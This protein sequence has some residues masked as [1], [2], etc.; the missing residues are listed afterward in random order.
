MIP[1]PNQILRIPASGLLVK[2]PTL[3]SGNNVGARSWTDGKTERP[4][5]P[6][7]PELCRHPSS[8]EL[9]WYR[10]CELV[11]EEETYAP[12]PEYLEV[13]FAGALRVDDFQKALSDGMANSA[14]IEQYICGRYWWA[15]NDPVR[16]G[17]TLAAS[18][19]DF[20][21]NLLRFCALLGT[22][23]P[24]RRLMNAEAARE[25]KD[26][27]AAKELLHFDFPA[28]YKPFADLL[29]RLTDECNS[30]VYLLA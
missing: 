9:F 2:I 23:D 14:A 4:G 3:M 26:F 21:E 20:H 24:Y 7:Q 28:A 11:G 6:E 15:A 18:D 19:S 12:R 10:Q 25:M 17:G 8:G 27:A 29:I 1:G 5:L 16:K 30:T 22:G 13:P